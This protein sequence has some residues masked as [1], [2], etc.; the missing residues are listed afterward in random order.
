MGDRLHTNP[1][2]TADGVLDAAQLT[3]GE[4]MDVL[5][6]KLHFATFGGCGWSANLEL[7]PDLDRFGEFYLDY[8]WTIPA[9]QPPTG[10]LVRAMDALLRLEASG[11]GWAADEARS[12]LVAAM[13]ELR[14]WVAGL[15]SI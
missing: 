9:Q 6:N 8:A 14:A 1:P 10:R 5:Y 3:P 7:R 13:E 12:Y 15:P 4:I 2:R 11:A